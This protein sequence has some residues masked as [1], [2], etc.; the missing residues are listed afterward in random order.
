MTWVYDAKLYDTK[1]QASCRVARLEDA[2]VASSSKARYISVFQT[3][4]GR[5]G[6]KMLLTHDSSESER[7]SK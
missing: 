3:K 5:Y 7:R 6:V 1:F 4:S 2:G